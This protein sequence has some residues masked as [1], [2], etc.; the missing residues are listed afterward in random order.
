MKKKICFEFLISLD[1]YERH[2]RSENY[3]HLLRRNNEKEFEIP[4]DY[5]FFKIEL[6]R[7]LE[8]IKEEAQNNFKDTNILR[9]LF[10]LNRY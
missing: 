1:N 8:R 10:K 4:E 9:D 2:D 3:K 7:F 5:E 6:I